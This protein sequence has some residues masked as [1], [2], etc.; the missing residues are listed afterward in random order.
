MS[1]SQSPE[2]Y[3]QQ[4]T[5]LLASAPNLTDFDEEWTLPPDTIRWL[6]RASAVVRAAVPLG[7][8][9]TQLDVAID[10][11]IK[12]LR[13][14]ENA[15]MIIALMNRALAQLELQLPASAQGAFVSV[16]SDFDTIAAFAKVLTAATVDVLIVD[17]YMDETAL[18]DFAVLVSE[19]IPVR[20]LTDSGS[21]KAGIEPMAKR[22]IEQYRDARPLALR[23]TPPRTLHDR[24]LLVDGADAWILTQS[25]KDF[26][27]RSPASLQRT[28][29]DTAKMKVDAYE[30]IWSAAAQIAAA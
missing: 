29:A 5:A 22:W 24:L 14:K 21:M 3:Y 19:N 13:T 7:L 28:D 15:K 4:L 18:T 27:K 9:A 20:L 1:N 16:G 6:G 23:A 11:L 26:A 8:V 17:P 12:T 30:G 2:A 25:L 10:N